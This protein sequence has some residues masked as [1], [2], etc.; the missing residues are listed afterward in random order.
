MATTRVTK[1]PSRKKA[2]TKLNAST[3]KVK[4]LKSKSTP[5]VDVPTNKDDAVTSIVK[6]HRA[7]VSK[8]LKDN[9]ED[10]DKSMI[11]AVT[12]EC[13][14]CF[15]YKRTA[16]KHDMWT[17]DIIEEVILNCLP[18]VNEGEKT[19]K[20]AAPTVKKT[21]KKAA[22]AKKATPVKAGSKKK[23]ATKKAPAKKETKKKTATKKVTTKKTVTKK[24][25]T[26]KAPAKKVTA[27]GVASL[28]EMKADI[29]KAK[30]VKKFELACAVLKKEKKIW[31]QAQD[32][33]VVASHLYKVHT[34]KGKTK[35]ADKLEGKG[36]K[37]YAKR[38]LVKT[39]DLIKELI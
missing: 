36:E 18:A 7:K 29:K 33:P 1:N 4:T 13:A 26:K 14:E 37:D 8:Y 5:V 16:K 38:R 15:V 22:P 39:L 20:K 34:G 35:L 23:V 3:R 24:A 12:R 19:E 27:R 6:A 9:F 25:P 31:M 30:G 28:E 10:V 21:V 32:I 11:D 2:R 17:K